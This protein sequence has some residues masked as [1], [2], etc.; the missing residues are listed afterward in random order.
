MWRGHLEAYLAHLRERPSRRG[1]NLAPAQI[2]KHY[3]HLQ[4]LFRWMADVEDIIKLSPFVK[5]SPPTVPE[6]P[7]PVLTVEQ[8]RLLLLTC[9]S[10]TFVPLRD[11]ALMWTFIDTGA[12]AGEVA[13]LR[14]ERPGPDGTTT[15]SDLDFDQD[16]I[17]VIGKGRRPRA[18]PFGAKCG[19][20]L[21][22]YLRARAKHPWAKRTDAVWL[23]SKGPLTDSGIRQILERRSVEAGI[24][25]V[26]RSRPLWTYTVTCPSRTPAGHWKPPVS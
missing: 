8:L 6:V 18:V 19:E 25:H 4:Q 22:R 9:H 5:M 2:A 24:P 20:A 10:K 7:V 1:G 23:G 21:R 17:H 26:P 15:M 11:R 12:R 3:R 13:P 16:V 14:L